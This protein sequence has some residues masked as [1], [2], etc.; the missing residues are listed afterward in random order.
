MRVRPVRGSSGPKAPEQE[1][2]WNALGTPQGTEGEDKRGG[3]RGGRGG[4]R[5]AGA[6]LPASRFLKSIAAVSFAFHTHPEPWLGCGCPNILCMGLCR[7]TSGFI[8]LGAWVLSLFETL[9]SSSQQL[10]EGVFTFAQCG[11]CWVA[12]SCWNVLE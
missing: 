7:A 2:S 10:G 3:E 8:S 5:E 1:R 4:W 11:P 6:N 12:R 9:L